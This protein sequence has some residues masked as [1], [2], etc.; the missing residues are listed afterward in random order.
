MA[1]K[2]K[3]LMASV[4]S[5]AAMA[6]MNGD[7]QCQCSRPRHLQQQVAANLPFS[8]PASKISFLGHLADPAM[9]LQRSARTAASTTTQRC[10]QTA[11]RPFPRRVRSLPVPNVK[12][13]VRAWSLWPAPATT[14]RQSN[15]F[16]T[17][18]D[19]LADDAKGTSFRAKDHIC[20]GGCVQNGTTGGQQGG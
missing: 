2:C 6:H 5:W 4:S 18:A 17:S 14:R 11:S 12:P 16:Q 3:I 1:D 19:L 7:L 13:I 20:D 9:L 8:H 15:T 10:R